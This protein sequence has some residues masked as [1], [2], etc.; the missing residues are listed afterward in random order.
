MPFFVYVL[1]CSDAKLYCGYTNDLSQRIKLHQAGKASKFTR[2]RLPVKLVHSEKY[3]SKSRAM[4]REHEI[5]K[6][7]RKKKLELIKNN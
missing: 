4:K 7:S 2:A 3:L 6:L 1:E 5:K